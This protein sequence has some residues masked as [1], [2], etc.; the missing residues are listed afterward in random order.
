MIAIF[1]REFKACFTNMTGWL[2][3]AALLALYGLYFYVFNLRSGHPYLSYSLSSIA[4]LTIIA[5]PILTMRIMSEDKK[6]KADQLMLTAPVSVTKIVLGKFLAV[7]A[8]F[9]IIILLIA[10]TPLI[11][12]L[13]GYVPMAENYVALLGYWLF[14]LACISIG[15]FVSNLF[16]SQ[17]I[18][19]VVSFVILFL[20]YMFGAI[21][22][23]FSEGENI[24][25]KIF[26]A[27]YLYGPLERLLAGKL[28]FGGIVYYLT[29]IALVLFLTTQVIQ[30]RRWSMSVNR[31]GLGAFSIG[32]ILIAFALCFGINFGMS[33][34]P[35]KYSVI[36]VT[37]NKLYTISDATVEYLKGL[38]EDVI[39][40]VWNS[41]AEADAT[42]KETVTRYDELSE[43]ISVQYISTLENPNFYQNF[44]DDEPSKDSLFVSSAKRSRVIGYSQIFETTFD[45]ETFSAVPV[46]YDGEG[47]ITSA[48][49]FVTLDDDFMPTIYILKGHDE[50]ALG[51]SF[52]SAMSKSNMSVKELT[53]LSVDSIPED[54]QLVIID[55]PMSDLSSD[56]TDK[57]D[58]YLKNGGTVIYA[59]NYEAGELNNIDN[60]LSGL[61]VNLIPGLIMDN[62]LNHMYNNVACYLLP[63]VLDSDYTSDITNGY[64]F[65][66]FAV[67]INIDESNSAYE[68]SNLLM[69]SADSVAK[70]NLETLE[71][72]EYEVGD[73]TGPFS[74]AVA[75][76]DVNSNGTLFV[77]GTIDLMSDEANEIVAGSN[78]ELFNAIIKTHVQDVKMDLPV[79][80]SKSYTADQLVFTSGIG[81]IY[82]LVITIL[83]PL[84]LII[85]GIIIWATRRKR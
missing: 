6:T 3:M 18:S 59:S 31:I 84:G 35:E 67:G 16:E 17:V 45:Y 47:Q 52:Y 83:A 79:I 81:L 78:L 13:S 22:S 33:K 58:A 1:K 25:T 34:L 15:V 77:F 39:I 21:A 76:T 50:T 2:F 26:N 20:G 75:V 70:T 82:G 61:G 41:E 74:I 32:T 51:N 36:D 11:L 29:V 56:D 8:I 57:I 42:L 80:A 5:I 4:F 9:T 60:Y 65:A 66:P 24:I 28:D 14:G 12:A 71:T 73:A 68:Y 64:V 54:A 69:T 40:Y 55:G 63:D 43:H 85:S 38:D 7:G 53:L 19:A 49:E 27:F 10:A 37:F 72:S 46:G 62:D 48:I 44:T 30:K 23:L